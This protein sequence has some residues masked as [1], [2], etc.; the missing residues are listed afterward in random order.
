MSK[1]GDHRLELVGLELLVLAQLLERWAQPNVVQ[2]RSE[3]WERKLGGFRAGVIAGRRRGIT[4]WI[5]PEIVQGEYRLACDTLRLL[6]T[7]C[8]NA[9]KGEV[10]TKLERGTV[11]YPRT[12]PRNKAFVL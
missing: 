12:V 8:V 9:K 11:S 2:K 5:A 4:R 3:E 6:G 7:A 10:V 1:T